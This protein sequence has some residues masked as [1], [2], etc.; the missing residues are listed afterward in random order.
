MPVVINRSGRDLYVNE[1]M[2]VIPFDGKKYIVSNEVLQKYRSKFEV[3]PV[4]L[5]DKLRFQDE[6]IRTLKNKSVLMNVF[7]LCDLDLDCPVLD[8][9]YPFHFNKDVES[10]VNRLRTSIKSIINQ[11]VRICVCNTSERCIR[12]YLKGLNVEYMHMPINLRS[13]YCKSKTIN[14]GAKSMIRSKYFF[15]SDIDL[16]YPPNFV[17]YMSL[18]T[19][20]KHP[21]RV[22]FSNHNIGKTEKI[23]ENYNE[24]VEIFKNNKDSC[25]AHKFFAP[26]NGL[27]HLAT[28]KKVG[29]YD[30]R[31]FG[32]GSEDSEFNYRM[33]LLNKYFQVDLDEVNTYHIWHELD[34]T[35]KRIK[36]NEQQWRY[37]VWYGETK[38]LK[39]IKAG[40]I[41]F[42]KNIMEYDW[43]LDKPVEQIMKEKL[44]DK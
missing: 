29:G 3:F 18:F 43:S 15:T 19:L 33:S 8:V 9:L 25:R 10:S 17:K 13:G 30:E 28:F 41:K 11:K 42:P 20:T 44:F 37:I 32:Y 4:E 14:L 7:T 6:I 36:I 1:I 38:N 40:S 22:I 16:V 5:Y 2:R 23:P 35:N 39:F 24:C 12:K 26:G 27:I 31:F 34:N 21:V